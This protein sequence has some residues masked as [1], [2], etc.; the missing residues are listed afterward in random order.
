MAKRIELRITEAAREHI[1]S[2][3]AKATM[4]NALPALFLTSETKELPASWYIAWYTEDQAR[5]IE[6]LYAENGFGEFTVRYEAD[7]M[8]LCIPQAPLVPQLGGRTLDY[9]EGRY[10]VT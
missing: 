1:R 8:E 3:V 5:D 6:K 10:T 9:R 2:V 4:P 7:G